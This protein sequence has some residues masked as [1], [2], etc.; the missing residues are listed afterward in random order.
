[1]KPKNKKIKERRRRNEL[2]LL[3]RRRGNLWM[4]AQVPVCAAL[5]GCFM[6]LVH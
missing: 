2:A 6:R 3:E 5:V 4:Y 1:M